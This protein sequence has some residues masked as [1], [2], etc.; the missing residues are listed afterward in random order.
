M[1]ALSSHKLN[2]VLLKIHCYA[3]NG[4]TDICPKNI[5]CPLSPQECKNMKGASD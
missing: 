2:I 4:E 3:K 1:P 5:D